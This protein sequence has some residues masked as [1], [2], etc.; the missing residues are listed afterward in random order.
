[1]AES[2]EAWFRRFL[3][4]TATLVYLAAAVELW[5]VGHYEGW[6]QWLPFGLIGVGVA[7]VLWVQTSASRRSVRSLR[8][9]SALVGA[10]S[11]LGIVFHVQGNL[12][13]EREVRPAEPLMRALWEAAQ[14]AS[15]LLAPGALALAAVLAVAATYRHPRS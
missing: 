15:P 6:R 13:F 7:T 1:M 10:G 12:A 4:G 2:V 8:V 5:L 11:L 3:L 14:G 9:A